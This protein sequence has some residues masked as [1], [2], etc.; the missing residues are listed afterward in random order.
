M[1]MKNYFAN[2]VSIIA[3][4]LV[5]FGLNVHI[6]TNEIVPTPSA[7]LVATVTPTFIPARDLDLFSTFENLL[8]ENKQACILPCWWGLKPGE[9]TL[10]EIANFLRETGFD[11]HQKYTIYSTLSLEDY[12]RSEQFVLYFLDN[13]YFA[14]FAMSFGFD[15]NDLMRAIQLRFSNPSTWLSDER[16]TIS[17]AK[18]LAQIEETPEIY[19]NEY[20][21][22]FRLSDYDLI[23][24]FKQSGV[25]VHYTF[26]VLDDNPEGTLEGL[27][28]C[29]GLDKTV[30]I[31]MS[32][33]AGDYE[34]E[35]YN[36]DW[37]TPENATGIGISTADFVQFFREHPD[38]CLDVSEFKAEQ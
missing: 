29:L 18:V 24:L 11:R 27:R 25:K 34:G 17:F 20:P 26:D 33:I 28:L 16:V 2:R 35:I 32:L 1:K 23:V 10:E 37:K 13:S 6:N 19:I 12:L 3:T 8:T 22:T 4:L 5:V 9:A 38:E 21:S 31:E 15:N 7:T 36:E 14:E 30:S